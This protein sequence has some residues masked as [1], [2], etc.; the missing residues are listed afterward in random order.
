MPSKCAIH[1]K[2]PFFHDHVPS[3]VLLF[4]LAVQSS[5]AKVTVWMSKIQN[6][7]CNQYQVPEAGL[8][9]STGPSLFP[10]HRASV[11]DLQLPQ[12]SS[13]GMAEPLYDHNSCPLRGSDREM[14]A[15]CEH[16]TAVTVG[17]HFPEGAHCLM[18]N[19]RLEGDL[20]HWNDRKH[21]NM[22]QAQHLPCVHSNI[23]I[24]FKVLSQSA[25]M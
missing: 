8:A 3:L 20:K 12:S 17:G 16:R 10:T 19:L 4:Q 24:F 11:E 1:C 6:N 23:R 13:R 22:D 9:L 14:W 2:R 7:L 15:E 21:I 25:T 18:D 5:C